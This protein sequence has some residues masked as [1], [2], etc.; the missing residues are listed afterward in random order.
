MADTT[1][2]TLDNQL[3]TYY[4]RVF[5]ERLEPQVYLRDWAQKKPIPKNEGKT[6]NFTQWN[7]PD[8]AS[9]K[10]SEGTPPTAFALSSRKVSATLA[11]Y[12]RVV[13]ITDFVDMTAI[14]PVV[15]EAVK[16][17]AD[18]AAKTYERVLQM[19]IWRTD[20]GL[21]GQRN[22]GSTVLSAF[23][24]SQLSGTKFNGASNWGF[25]VIFATSTGRLSATD[26]TN[27]SIS[28]QLS[29]I[30]ISK[31]V[32]KLR[33]LNAKPAMNG[34]FV[35]YTDDY[36]LRDLMVA[37]PNGWVD[38]YKYA[39]PDMIL[40]GEAGKIAG[41]R[42]FSSSLVPKYRTTAHSCSLSFFFGQEAF[43]LTEID[44]AVR[45]IVKPME[46]V[47]DKTD[48]LNQYATVGYKWTA[49]AVALNPSAGRVLITATRPV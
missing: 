39:D 33:D 42:L 30:S 27:P 7:A 25:K 35:G 49:A 24:S 28:A 29:K 12:G 14:S 48:T 44:G 8:P 47:Y 46:N 20:L 32:A 43:G 10:L 11:Q 37:D 21:S 31:V 1:S 26:K 3:S 23:M 41:V 18:S 5:I 36:A 19:V 4:N 16:I 17:L 38:A 22:V 40:K 34:A 13:K 6:V 45:I 15:E 2:S 9:S